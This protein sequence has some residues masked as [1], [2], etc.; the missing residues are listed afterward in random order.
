[1]CFSC[2]LCSLAG[3]LRVSDVTLKEFEILDW[4]LV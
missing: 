2:S 1:M 4:L 3:D